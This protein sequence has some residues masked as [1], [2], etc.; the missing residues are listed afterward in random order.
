M[1][2]SF[3]GFFLQVY[4]GLLIYQLFLD[5]IWFAVW[6]GPIS[7]GEDLGEDSVSSPKVL[8]DSIRNM[9]RW[10]GRMIDGLE[11]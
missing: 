8:R 10:C 3:G 6:A 2:V 11:T 1:P 9:D 7:D 4:G 5:V